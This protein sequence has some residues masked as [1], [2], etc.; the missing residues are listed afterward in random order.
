VASAHY[1][2]VPVFLLRGPP[3]RLLLLPLDWFVV[4]GKEK[5]LLD[6]DSSSPLTVSS[7]SSTISSSALSSS[8][9]APLTRGATTASTSHSTHQGW[10]NE[11]QDS[12]SLPIGMTI[13]P[14]PGGVIRRFFRAVVV[15]AYIFL[16]AGLFWPLFS[17][18]DNAYG[19]EVF[20]ALTARATYLP[21]VAG[22]TVFILFLNILLDVDYWTGWIVYLGL[23]LKACVVI[24]LFLTLLCASTLILAAPV[25][26][27]FVVAPLGLYVL[28]LFVLPG[29][30]NLTLLWWSAISLLIVAIASF[31]GWGMWVV[32]GGNFW[33][34]DLQMDYYIR[35]E[36]VNAS[37]F[38]NAS[39]IQ[40]VLDSIDAQ[41]AC[42]YGSL[43]CFV[44]VIVVGG[45]C[46]FR[47]QSSHTFCTQNKTT[48]HISWLSLLFLASWSLLVSALLFF[49]VR[50]H[51][52][53]SQ[54]SSKVDPATQIFITV[55]LICLFGM[56]CFSSQTLSL[57]K[58]ALNF[59][60]SNV[61][62]KRM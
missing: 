15:V 7:A 23:V 60:Y 27:Y 10:Q 62:L 6:P 26:V 50:A 45:V 2:L 37:V 29:M 44:V 28:K 38:A 61:F 8:A 22:L 33:D 54:G 52:K 24:G 12:S 17:L 49:T 13:A 3:P 18:G 20:L 53:F 1:Y 25:V 40:S 32:E 34:S 11:Q 46:S 9:Q 55:L 5:M 47:S 43:L 31:I 41:G 48:A 39:Q 59:I 36:C 14:D 19:D 57:L 51:V 4:V 42:E 58:A 21:A 16:A 56:V 30:S 35:L